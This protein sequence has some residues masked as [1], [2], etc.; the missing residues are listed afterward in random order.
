MVC[1]IS[2]LCRRL[3]GLCPWYH[4]AATVGASH[5]NAVCDP[6]TFMVGSLVLVLAPHGRISHAPGNHQLNVPGSSRDS[7]PLGI[8]TGPVP[9]N[10]YHL[11]R[12]P[13]MVSARDF[14]YSF[15]T[16][17]AVRPAGAS[18]WT[19]G[20][21]FRSDL[22][23]QRGAV[24]LLHGL[25]W[26]VDSP[27]TGARP[28]DPLLPAALGWRGRGRNLCRCNRPSYF[29]WLY[30]ISNWPH[31][32]RASNCRSSLPGPAVLVVWVQVDG[33][34]NS[35]IARPH[36]G[37]ILLQ[38]DYRDSAH[39]A[40]HGSLPV[41][42]ISDRSRAFGCAD[43][44]AVPQANRANSGPDQPHTD[45][46]LNRCVRVVL[47]TLSTNLHAE[48]VGHPQGPQFLWSPY[49][50]TPSARKPGCSRVAAWPDTPRSPIHEV[51]QR[52]HSLLRPT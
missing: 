19:N 40:G 35:H 7:L 49:G 4:E 27:E 26:G 50:A 42:S 23:A 46:V 16:V 6:R 43:P 8:A 24:C 34:R 51:S 39:A 33:H 45:R 14:P 41:L 44:V 48:G 38:P 17:D 25:P 9:L 11:F 21:H 18:G 10:L 30:R 52:T 3:V 29:P 1:G 37:A 5:R 2:H 22:H 20:A 47:R 32:L 12:Q 13:E 15:W 36:A 31:S 28:S